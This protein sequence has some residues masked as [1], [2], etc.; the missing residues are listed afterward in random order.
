M[1]SGSKNIFLFWNKGEKNVPLIHKMNIDNIK[2]RLKNSDWNIILTTLDT[3]DKYYVGNLIELPEYFFQIKNKIKDINSLGGNQ[4][5]IVR[6]RLLEKYGGIYFDTSVI[7]LKDKIENI[8]LYKK[9][10]N[11]DAELAGYTNY[12]FTRKTEDNQNYFDL[13]KDGIELGILYSKKNCKLLKIFNQEIDRYW[14]WKNINNTYKEYPLFKE[15][16]L[17]PVSFLNEYHV[18][19]SIYHLIIT[20]DKTLLDNLTVQSMHMKGKENSQE[21]GP[22][23]ISDRFCRDKD[24]YGSA[25]PIKIL[26]TFLEGNVKTNT[27]ITT[28]LEERIDI[29]SKMDL[30]VIPGYMRIEIEK[31]FQYLEDFYNVNSCYKYFY[32]LPIKIT[33]IT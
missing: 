33:M 23:S 11:E 24:G 17:T 12:T 3:N 16:G 18:H 14:K 25:E 20:R 19:Y 22:Y 7:L 32:Q 4:S 10:I 8:S 27:G 2:N 9:F 13:A 29:F 21:D 5:D 6:L 28:S 26:N 1:I 31:R 30:I 15:F